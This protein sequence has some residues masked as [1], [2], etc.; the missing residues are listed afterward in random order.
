MARGATRVGDHV[1][2][3]KVHDYDEPAGDVAVF[4]GYTEP[5]RQIMADYR[6]AGR[7]VV[8]LDMAY[9]GRR[10]NGHKLGFHKVSVNGRHPTKYFQAVKHKHDRVRQ[11]GLHIRP[12]SAGKKIML[13]GMSTKAAAAENVAGWDDRAARSLIK[14]RAPLVYRPKPRSACKVYKTIHGAEM[15]DPR[16]PIEKSLAQ[17]GGVVTHH[18]NV[19]V[20]ALLCGIPIYCEDG[21]AHGY[22]VPTM[23]DI[24]GATLPDFNRAQFAADLAYCQWLPEEMGSGL[25]WR[26]LKDEGLI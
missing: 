5:L 3:K 13:A 25:T 1:T 6:E 16:R 21:V 23:R 20:D 24:L 18:S 22:S 8:Y 9:W 10:W 7:S 19:A 12:P 14:M 15:S 2:I 4:Y 17:I 26:H 11:F